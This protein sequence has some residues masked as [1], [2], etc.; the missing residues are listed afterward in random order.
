MHCRKECHDARYVR[1]TRLQTY[2]T[3]RTAESHIGHPAQRPHTSHTASRQCTVLLQAWVAIGNGTNLV[4]LRHQQLRP[5][6]HDEPAQRARRE[7][8]GF[9][10]QRWRQ[11]AVNARDRQPRPHLTVLRRLCWADRCAFKPHASLLLATSTPSAARTAGSRQGLFTYTTSCLSVP[12]RTQDRV[13]DDIAATQHISIYQHLDVH[14][15]LTIASKCYM[16]NIPA[17]YTLGEKQSSV[18]G[19]TGAALAF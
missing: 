12:A 3:R 16:V 11:E 19:H 2:Y 17:V 13:H 9:A 10:Q 7:V 8:R 14:R 1:T 18:A 4:V 5:S 6:R 15:W